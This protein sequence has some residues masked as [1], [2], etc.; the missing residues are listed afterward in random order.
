MDDIKTAKKEIIDCF[1]QFLLDNNKESIHNKAIE[2]ERRFGSLAT[3]NDYYK[4]KIVPDSL[5]EA[6]SSLQKIYQFGEGIFDDKK[7]IAEI[8]SIFKKLI[9]KRK[10]N[11]KT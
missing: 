7:S 3:L 10:P 11:D 2:L 8:K 6:I 1:R 4:T 5:I 9:I